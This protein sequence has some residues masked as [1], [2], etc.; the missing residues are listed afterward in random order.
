MVKGEALIREYVLKYAELALFRYAWLWRSCEI[1]FS[2]ITRRALK[3][4]EVENPS[5]ATEFRKAVG[6]SPIFLCSLL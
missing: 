6:E 2:S 1:D 4:I 5:N 3:I